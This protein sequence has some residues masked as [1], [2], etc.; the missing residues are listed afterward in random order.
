MSSVPAGQEKVC[1]G[2]LTDTTSA[3]KTSSA[4]IDDL[5]E[6]MFFWEGNYK[7]SNLN[8]RTRAWVGGLG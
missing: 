1:A 7:G 3:Q 6:A 4:L 8:R 5:R 2:A